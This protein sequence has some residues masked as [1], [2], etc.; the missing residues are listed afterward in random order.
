MHSVYYTNTNRR[1]SICTC[2]R[3]QGCYTLCPLPSDFFSSQNDSACSWIEVSGSNSPVLSEADR[4]HRLD[5][6]YILRHVW[7]SWSAG[8]TGINVFFNDFLM[9]FCLHMYRDFRSFSFRF[10]RVNFITVKETTM[11]QTRQ[12]ASK[13][14]ITLT[15]KIAC[16]ILTT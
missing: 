7:N 5:S 13:V 16:I 11:W 15:G 4:K 9:L 8:K 2:L 1:S 6:C 12:N 3:R 14:A 10:S